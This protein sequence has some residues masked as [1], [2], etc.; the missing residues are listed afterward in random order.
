MRIVT[1]D[2]SASR[3]GIHARVGAVADKERP[4]KLPPV[5]VDAPKN[6]PAKHASATAKPTARR[7]TAR[8]NQPPKPASQTAAAVDDGNGPNNNNSG[9]PLQQAPSLGKTGTKLADLPV[10]VQI[11]PRELLSEQGATMLRDAVSNASGIN[12]GGQDA[13]L[14]RPFSDPRPEC[15]G[16]YRR[17]LRWRSARRHLAF[18]Q[19]RAADRNSGGPGLGA[20]RQRPARRDDQHRSL[21]S[22]AGLHWGSSLQAGSFGT[23]TNS[24]YITGPTGIAGLNYRLDTTFSRADGFRDLAAA[25]TKSGRNSPGNSTTTRSTSPSMSGISTK[26]R[27]RTA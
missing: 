25:T 4:T 26:R 5:Q 19:R 8:S 9:P 2:F 11:I 24:D 1:P 27:I 15:P 14:F 17:L 6:R 22:V 16:L 18:A 3:C 20:V 10:S 21:R 13:G 23:V 12:Y 7:R